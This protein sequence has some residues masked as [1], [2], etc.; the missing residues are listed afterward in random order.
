MNRALVIIGLT[1]LVTGLPLN[2][3]AVYAQNNQGRIEGHVTNLTTGGPP[4]EPL[5]S[6][7]V[8][9]NE[10]MVLHSGREGE[11]NVTGLPPG[12]YTVRLD[13]PPGYS[14]AQEVL[15]ATIWGD[16]TEVV[17]L[18]YY[19]GNV[20]LPTS[21]PDVTPAVTDVENR[22]QPLGSSA[23]PEPTA[24]IGATA[25]TTA[26]AFSNVEVTTTVQPGRA[27][28]RQPGYPA[29]LLLFLAGV[30]LVIAGLGVR[31]LLERSGR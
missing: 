6:V 23:T 10:W 5:P 31:Q 17:D 25:T 9:V 24:T 1:L 19:E 11:W 2:L 14:P 30:G 15:T 7:T 27:G 8:L 20:P 13:L 16:N 21:G 4:A 12:V 18:A 26:T 28:I 29:G 3:P 22:V